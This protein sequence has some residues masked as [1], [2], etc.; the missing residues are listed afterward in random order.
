MQVLLNGENHE[1]DKGATLA[2]LLGALDLANQRYAVE[3]NE[4]LVPRS[5]HH[6]HRLEAGD[7]IEVVQAIGGG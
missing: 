4:E 3:I 1:I 7:R 6:S 5:Q 2:Q